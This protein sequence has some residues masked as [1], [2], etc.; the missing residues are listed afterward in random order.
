M[1]VA[2]GTY[3]VNRVRLVAFEQ[4][5]DF[6]KAM[7]WRGPSASS[8][9]SSR[10]ER[11]G[12]AAY[13]SKGFPSTYSHTS[14]AAPDLCPRDTVRVID[15]SLARYTNKRYDGKSVLDV[16]RTSIPVPLPVYEI[17]AVSCTCPI[18]NTLSNVEITSRLN[19]SVRELVPA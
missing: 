10:S 9:A 2:G 13:T 7:L 6:V 12:S 19:L 3:R 8:A 16:E 18:C 4:V 11:S 15:D 17:E 5:M 14:H 1:Q